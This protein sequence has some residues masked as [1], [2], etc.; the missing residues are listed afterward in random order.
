MKHCNSE[1]CSN[2]AHLN[3]AELHEGMAAFASLVFSS[4]VPCNTHYSNLS[5]SVDFQLQQLAWIQGKATIMY[6]LARQFLATCMQACCYTQASVW[7][8]QAECVWE[9]IIVPACWPQ[10]QPEGDCRIWQAN[11]AGNGA[12]PQVWSSSHAPAA[13]A[14]SGELLEHGNA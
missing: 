13:T 7:C 9:G 14:C 12:C 2:H 3:A 10:H 5:Q 11:S 6:L 1:Y 4:G 8:V